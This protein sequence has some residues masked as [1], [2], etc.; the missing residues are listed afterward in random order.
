MVSE[1]I[2][3][4][5]QL[6]NNLSTN[7]NI[8]LRIPLFNGWQTR[9]RIKLAKIDVKN[10]EL[11]EE[12]AKVHLRQDIEQAYLNMENAWNRYKLLVEQVAA[13]SES[14]RAAEVRFQSGVGT[15]VDY[16]V[17]KNNLDRAN[18]NLIMARY[19]YLLRTKVLDYYNGTLMVQ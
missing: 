16:L 8:G 19:D 7:I 2:V 10:S 14:F 13:L 9:S 11:Q 12:A 17:V 18:T 4:N 15:S 6:S 3:Y 5:N 1:K